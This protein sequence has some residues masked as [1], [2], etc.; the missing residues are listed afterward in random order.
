[1]L[2]VSKRE[3]RLLETYLRASENIVRVDSFNFCI[4]LRLIRY[5][6]N[7]DYFRSTGT[8]LGCEAT[9]SDAMK[10]FMTV[11]SFLRGF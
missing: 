8:L 4:D 9:P 6:Q 2:G 5:G 10:A 11:G 7:M 3:L 1:M